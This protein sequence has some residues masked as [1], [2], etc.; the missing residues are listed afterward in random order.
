LGTCVA[1]VAFAVVVVVA[2]DVADVVVVV[3]VDDVVV[4]IVAFCAH[5][6]VTSATYAIIICLK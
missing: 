1:A 4:L 2:A 6:F 5:G 3:V